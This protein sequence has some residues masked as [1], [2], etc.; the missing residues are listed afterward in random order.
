[1]NASQRRQARRGVLRWM[2]R[3]WQAFHVGA[4]CVERDAPVR[5]IAHLRLSAAALGAAYR[6]LAR[7]AV[8]QPAAG[9]SRGA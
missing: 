9:R 5:A 8:P 4:D 2:P 3:M 1:M 6:K 7:R